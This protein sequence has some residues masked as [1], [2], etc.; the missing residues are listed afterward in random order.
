[1]ATTSQAPQTRPDPQPPQ[2]GRRAFS[3]PREALWLAAALA[4]G[5]LVIPLLIW[6]VGNRVLGPYTHTQDPTAG[7]GPARLLADFF[8]GLGHGS[9]VF[10]LVALGP[11]L[12]L[13][14]IRLLYGLLR[15]GRAP[16]ASRG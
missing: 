13:S 10:W 14:F 1:M 9:V 15:A 16:A 2:G 8:A 6:A 11:Y 4:L 7:T 5:F 3:W 12:L